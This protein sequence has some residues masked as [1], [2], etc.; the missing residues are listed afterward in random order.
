MR[1][2]VPIKFSLS[3]ICWSLLLLWVR[4]FQ[5]FDANAEGF[6]LAEQSASA[7][8]QATA[9]AAQADTPSALHYNPAGMVQLRRVQYSVGI[10]LIGGHFS[11]K[12]PT[13]TRARGDFDG[14]VANPPP[15]NFYLI[16][17]LTD[18]GFPYLGNT[19]V[20]L[21]VTSPFGLLS[22]FP[23]DAPFATAGFFTALPLIDIKPTIAFK[24][25]KY[26]AFGAGIDIYTFSDLL[27]EGQAEI[28]QVAGPE[29]GDPSL[30]FLGI[31]PGDELE[32][33]GTDTAVGF[34]VGML[35]TPWRTSDGKPRLNLAFVYRSQVTLKLKGDFLSNG[36]RV[37][38]ARADLHLPQIFTGGIAF[39]PLRNSQ[40]EWKLEVNVD[41]ADW[42]SFKNL[43]VELSN[44]LTLPQ[45][46]DWKRTVV[47]NIGTEYKWLSP[48]SLPDW[49]IALRGGYVRSETPIPARTFEPTVPGSDYNGIS[50]GVGLFCTDRGMFF[51]LTQCHSGGEGWLPIRGIGLDLAY[52]I[53]S[54]LR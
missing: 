10:N 47:V 22:S 7:L 30:G 36:R 45:P 3:F 16:A 37:A 40:H 38:G 35:F 52:Q 14:T 54:T 49:E 53:L 2:T 24:L 12:S 29:F 27:G 51:G 33:N 11:F 43:D 42:S 31:A 5:P 18:L 19:T 21:G 17:N 1:Q 8:G 28:K 32:V 41:Y 26:L 20:G 25:N 34:N 39:W 4:L 48:A 15:S 46:R 6:R 50:I 13:G 44:G 23:T 9:V